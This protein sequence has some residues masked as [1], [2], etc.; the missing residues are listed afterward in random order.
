[1]HTFLLQVA[2]INLDVCWRV[3]FPVPVRPHS[4]NRDPTQSF[5]NETSG[6]LLQNSC[7]F[8]GFRFG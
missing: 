7:R 5:I 3:P 1:M 6:F 2:F 8:L 4:F